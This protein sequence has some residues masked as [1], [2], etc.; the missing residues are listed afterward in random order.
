MLVI[1][2]TILRAAG[3]E[4][5]M[6]P[7]SS[8]CR[9]LLTH[10]YEICHRCVINSQITREWRVHSGNYGRRWRVLM[11]S[12]GKFV[13][14]PRIDYATLKQSLGSCG[15]MDSAII[16]AHKDFHLIEAALSTESLVISLDEKARAIFA[17]AALRVRQFGRICWINPIHHET[18]IDRWLQ[19]DLDTPRAWNLDPERERA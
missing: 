12:R 8:I 9:A 5:S 15:L 6:H 7:D 10:V 19:G 2:T 17:L 18:S 3:P 16:A 14:A 11:A 13:S 4:G 1:D